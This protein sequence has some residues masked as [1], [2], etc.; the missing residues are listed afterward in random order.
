MATAVSI[1]FL[2]AVH[3]ATSL[4]ILLKK[5]LETQMITYRPGRY[6]LN[7]AFT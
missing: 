2:Q 6:L 3:T 7:N 1:H 4:I 5:K